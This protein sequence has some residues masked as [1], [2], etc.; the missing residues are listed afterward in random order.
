MVDHHKPPLIFFHHRTNSSTAQNGSYS[1]MRTTSIFWRSR[2]WSM[3]GPFT[4]ELAR[5]GSWSPRIFHRSANNSIL[6][7]RSRCR[8]QGEQTENLLVSSSHKFDPEQR[9]WQRYIRLTETASATYC[10]LCR[11]LSLH[12]DLI[13]IKKRGYHPTCSTLLSPNKRGGCCMWTRWRVSGISTSNIFE[14]WKFSWK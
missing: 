1:Q 6:P 10:R 8:M 14:F 3:I 9:L 12:N 11:V 2:S 4:V 7:S 13:N 5:C